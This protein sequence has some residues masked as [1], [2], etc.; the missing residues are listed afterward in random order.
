MLREIGRGQKGARGLDRD[1]TRDLVGAMV[2][3]RVGDLEMG[4]ILVAWRFKG[5][6]LDELLGALDAVQQ[7]LDPIEVDPARPRLSIPSYNGARRQINQ[8]PLLAA[9]LARAGVQV[10]VHGVRHDPGRLTT[11]QILAALTRQRPGLACVAESN[12]EACRA[13]QSAVPTFVALDVLAPRFAEFLALRERLGVRHIG[14]TIAKLIDPLTSGPAGPD[15]A[16]QSGRIPATVRLASFTHPEFNRLQHE[17]LERIGATALVM[18]GTD[19]EA[20]A[21]ARRSLQLD[22]IRDGRTERMVDEADLHE[23]A[24]ITATDGSAGEAAGHLALPPIDVL[25]VD[26][27]VAWTL[28]VLDGRRPMPAALQAQLDALLVVAGR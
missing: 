19:G 17:L 5:E 7:R 10:I 16:R 15:P 18:R 25:D 13:V 28:D 4:G 2:D 21:G 20:H 11:A 27:T 8:I 24:A 9:C 22:L 1:T 12:G 14:H 3:G 6:S 23:P 26:A